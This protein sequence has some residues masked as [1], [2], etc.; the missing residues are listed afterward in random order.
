MFLHAFAQKLFCLLNSIFCNNIAHGSQRSRCT[1]RLPYIQHAL[2][3]YSLSLATPDSR[4]SKSRY[5]DHIGHPLTMLH[6]NG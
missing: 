3:I 4:A 5:T 1:I 6:Q 2:F